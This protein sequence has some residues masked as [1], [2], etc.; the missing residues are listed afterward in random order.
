MY[1]M[2]PATADSHAL[3]RCIERRVAALTGISA[4]ED[5]ALLQRNFTPSSVELPLSCDW[6]LHYDSHNGRP[7]RVVTALMYLNTV[8]EGGETIFPL[9]GCAEGS[10]L[11]NDAN[12]LL[13]HGYTHTS[14]AL[15]GASSVSAAA[16]RLLAA[17]EDPSN[18]V[19]VS[20]RKGRLCLFYS[21]GNCFTCDG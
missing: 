7:L 20:A 18:G 5:E 14:A 21:T 19:R 15:E 11:L 2:L 1:S 12:L 9:A 16:T 13:K 10:S 3:V 6:G 8:A 4:H 17:A